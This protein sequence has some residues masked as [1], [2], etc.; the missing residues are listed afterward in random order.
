MDALPLD[1]EP[2]DP[3]HWFESIAQGLEPH[4]ITLAKSLSGGM[5]PVGATIAR[6]GLWK[7]TLGAE[8]AP[9]TD[10]RSLRD[11]VLKV[12]NFPVKCI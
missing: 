6:C 3:G 10:V 11:R 1:G 4:I 9:E 2:G 7:Q 8:N 5:V 12:A